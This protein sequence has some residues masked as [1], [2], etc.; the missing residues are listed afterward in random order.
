MP[1][2]KTKSKSKP[3]LPAKKT[4]LHYPAT[5]KDDMRRLTQELKKDPMW[6]SNFVHRPPVKRRSTKNN[7]LILNREL[8]KSPIYV[9]DFIYR[10]S[11][12]RKIAN[13]HRPLMKKHLGTKI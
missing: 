6:V 12:T 1:T 7:S 2:A 9:N 5:R 4:R 8:E 10:P 13:K 3:K 11:R